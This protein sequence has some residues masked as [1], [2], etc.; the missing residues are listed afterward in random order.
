MNEA[1]ERAEQATLR[2]EQ[3][4]RA[5]RVHSIERHQAVDGHVEM[6]SVFPMV[7]CCTGNA[8]KRLWR[9]CSDAAHA[10]CKAHGDCTP[11]CRV[12]QRAAHG[13]LC[14][15]PAAA[16]GATRCGCS[17]V[18]AVHAPEEARAG[19]AVSGQGCDAAGVGRQRREHADIGELHTPRIP[20]THLRASS[21]LGL[22][23]SCLPMCCSSARQDRWQL[24]LQLS[25]DALPPGVA[26]TLTEHVAL[27]PALCAHTL[28]ELSCAVMQ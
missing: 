14:R 26:Q 13:P 28:H 19:H 18:H 8:A 21:C 20:G 23:R 12:R 15:T 11:G 3:A 27:F 7:R 16:H 10:L 6:N 25:G 9:A 22:A 24:M 2:A 4:E 1:V 5:L 17:D